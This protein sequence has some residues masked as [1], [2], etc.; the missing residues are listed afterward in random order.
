[1]INST[2]GSCFCPM[3]ESRSYAKRAD[4][5]SEKKDAKSWYEKV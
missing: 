4:M 3:R 1:M 2:F 5:D